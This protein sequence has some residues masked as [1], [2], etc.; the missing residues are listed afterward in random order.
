MKRSILA[1]LLAG[2]ARVVDKLGGVAPVYLLVPL[3]GTE[4][5]PFGLTPR[6]PFLTSWMAILRVSM[7]RTP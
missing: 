7:R 2:A 1:V 4:N 3:Q 5:L 6:H